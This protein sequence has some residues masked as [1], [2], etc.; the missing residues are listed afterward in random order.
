MNVSGP[1]NAVVSERTYSPVESPNGGSDS[2]FASA[3]PYH[4]HIVKGDDAGMIR[5][6][7]IVAGTIDE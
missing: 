4:A 7:R 6:F 2:L 1:E 5:S 3:L